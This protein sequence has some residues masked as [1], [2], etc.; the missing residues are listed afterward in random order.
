MAG[1]DLFRVGVASS[2]VRCRLQREMFS[3]TSPESSR[4]KSSVLQ[5]LKSLSLISCL[6]ESRGAR[7]TGGGYI[8]ELREESI[9][10]HNH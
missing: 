9:L 8:V 6:L 10:Q 7:D 4:V 1:R 3:C 2:E 5:S